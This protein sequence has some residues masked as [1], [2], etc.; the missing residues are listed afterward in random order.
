MDKILQL[1]DRFYGTGEPTLMVVGHSIHGRWITEKAA[2]FRREGVV[3]K[4][5]S[6][7]FDYIQNV[8][9]RDG[10]TFVLVNALGAYETW[11]ANRNGDGFPEKAY[12]VGQLPKC[13][14][15]QC[16]PPT[17]KG[18]LSEE[19][20]LLHHYKTFETHGGIYKHHINKNA[21]KSLGRVERAFWNPEMHRVELLLDIVNDKDKDLIQRINDLDFPAVSMGC[22]PA[23]TLIT[24]NDGTRKKVEDI[25]IGDLVRTHRGRA[26]RVTELHR[27]PYRGDI[28]TVHAEAHEPVTFT[29]EH[30]LHVVKRNTV[31]VKTDKANFRWK[32]DATLEPDWVHASCLNEQDFLLEPIDLDDSIVTP[33]RKITK[34]Y[35]EL[36]VYNFEVEEDNSYVAGG[37]AVH[38]CRV[39]WDVCTI[40]G[41]RAPTRAQYCEHSML[42]L[43]EIL[44]ET[45]ELCAVLN[46][47]PVFFDIS[48][49]FK[50]ADRQGF[51]FKKVAEGVY[52]LSSA[53]LGEHVAEIHQKQ[54]RIRKLSDIQ[55]KLIGDMISAKSGPNLP[56]DQEALIAGYK[57]DVLPDAMKD[58]PPASDKEI[59]ALASY[60]IP[61]ILATL[62]EKNATLSTGEI[63][64]VFLRKLGFV[65]S[66]DFIDRVVAL[67]PVLHEVIAQHP[68]LL[69]K[70]GEAFGLDHPRPC[71]ALTKKLGSWLEKRATFGEWLQQQWHS[72]Y[73]SLSGQTASFG[74][75]YLHGAQEPPRTD[76]LT[77]TDPNTGQ[78]YRTTRGAAMQADT[79][80]AK[81]LLG[82]AAMIGVPL[83]FGLGRFKA[84]HGVLGTGLRAA[85]SAAVALPAAKWLVGVNRPYRNPTY[86]TDQGIPV[87]GGTEFKGA[88]YLESPLGMTALLN[89]CAFDYYERLHQIPS[90]S[91]QTALVEK[92]A[93]QTPS[94]AFVHFLQNASPLSEKAA[95]L[96][97]TTENP[98]HSDFDIPDVDLAPLAARIG[99]LLTS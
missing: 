30:P 45:G 12:K 53:D 90:G 71:P 97:S 6:P 22:V 5:A 42:H 28:Y 49:V 72:P 38:N 31:R 92:I 64:Q 24:M 52:V 27:R 74:P 47:S 41:H 50:P 35:A 77:M 32:P 85:G 84:L 37:L 82:S 2:S 69:N 43:R 10:H 88:E 87:S 33:I 81:A 51:M 89:K 40:C 16:L 1:D 79:T 36:D 91:W 3:A 94:S 58:T 62:A 39:R 8:Q 66:T 13:G 95:W 56:P 46:P 19:E 21:G 44:P 18:W 75:G 98:N 60:A 99:T 93:R 14:D 23:G 34:L 86:V 83:F 26:R 96:A 15:K 78:V 48:M 70:L 61:E 54:A 76:L 67:Q 80:D 68:D 65:T 17:S 7:A 20:T 73:T 59:E 9:P 25:V 29:A 57:K 63:A 55:K 4:Y 11:D